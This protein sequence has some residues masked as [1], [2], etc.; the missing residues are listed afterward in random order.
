[1][2]IKNNKIRAGILITL[3]A[4][5]LM[6]T[7]V[8]IAY[9]FNDLS[10]KYKTAQNTINYLHSLSKQSAEKSTQ[11]AQNFYQELDAIRANQPEPTGYD[12]QVIQVGGIGSRIVSKDAFSSDDQGYLNA[13]K[14]IFTRFNRPADIMWVQCK[15]GY[16]LTEATTE[17]ENTISNDEELGYMVE[18]KDQLKNQVLIQC[19]KL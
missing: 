10:N 18:L 15:D 9:K 14:Y 4:G 19:Q 8:F 3:L 11:D 13:D 6:L 7:V 16:K 1:M 5:V 17:T 12:G 2:E